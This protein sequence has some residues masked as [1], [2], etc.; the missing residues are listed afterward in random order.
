MQALASAPV[1]GAQAVSRALSLLKIIARHHEVGVPASELVVKTGLNRVTAA[2]LLASLAAE[3]FVKQDS[4]LSYTLGIGAVQLGLAAMRS[5]PI[6]HRCRPMMIRLARQTEDT[7]FLL[8]RNGDHGQCVHHEEGS[9]PVRTLVLK[10]GDLR[11]LGVGSAGIALMAS[12]PDKDIKAIHA[13]NQAAYPSQ[14]ANLRVL[15]QMI[16]HVRRHGYSSSAGLVTEGVGGVGMYFEIAPGYH[17]AVS[18]AAVSSRMSRQRRTWIAEQ[19]G[20][21]LLR[22]GL[23]GLGVT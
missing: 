19:I 12:L 3:G 21:E 4:R 11:L 7:V 9:F 5:N 10:P 20:S 16:D 22:E 6:I 15:L 13:R 14:L 2:R 17:A 1:K 18:V 23:R 8:V